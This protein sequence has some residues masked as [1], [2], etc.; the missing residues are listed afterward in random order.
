V[1]T[2]NRD[3]GVARLCETTPNLTNIHHT[4]Q[5]VKHNIQSF[6]APYV[7]TVLGGPKKQTTA[8]LP[9]IVLNRFK[10]CQ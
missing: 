2:Q 8:K 4:P 10:A 9:K 6:T 3:T 1:T 5:L 7:Y